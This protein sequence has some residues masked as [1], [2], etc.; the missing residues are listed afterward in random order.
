MRWAKVSAV[1][2]GLTLLPVTGG[3]CARVGLA[4]VLVADDGV[5]ALEP[6]PLLLALAMTESILPMLVDLVDDM[7]VLNTVVDEISRKCEIEGRCSG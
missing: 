5:L 2:L 4:D 3:K 7:S 6:R 1:N